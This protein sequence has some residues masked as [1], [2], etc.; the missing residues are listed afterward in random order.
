MAKYVC[1]PLPLGSV[2]V[3]SAFL[4]AGRALPY[5]W[6]EEDAPRAQFDDALNACHTIGER[7]I[8]IRIWSSPSSR[9]V[10]AHGWWGKFRYFVKKLDQVHSVT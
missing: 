8:I 6:Q 2:L 4:G 9:V 1:V 5:I 10:S 7:W 3:D